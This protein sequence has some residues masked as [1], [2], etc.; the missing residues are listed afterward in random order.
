MNDGLYIELFFYDISFF[1]FFTL[2]T[3]KYSVLYSTLIRSLTGRT[4]NV[5]LFTVCIYFR[6][7]LSSQHV[8]FFS[9]LLTL[10]FL[11]RI[12]FLRDENCKICTLFIYFFF[13]FII[14]ML[15]YLLIEKK[16]KR[17]N[18]M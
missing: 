8:Y 18:V 4:N 6:L 12:F 3:S 7:K 5:D 9:S 17:L 2:P 15:I 13:Y 10:F 1:F 16:R 11:W 14:Y